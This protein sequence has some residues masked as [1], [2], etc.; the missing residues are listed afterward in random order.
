M[1]IMIQERLRKYRKERG[2]TQEE[3]AQHLGISV[4]AVSKWERGEGYPDITLLPAIASFYNVTVDDLLGV[5]EIEKQKKYEAYVQECTAL[6]NQGKMK[7]RLELWKKAQAEFPNNMQVLSQVMITYYL[8]DRKEHADEIIQ[9]GERILQESTEND[10]RNQA[11]VRIALAYADKG[12]YEQ[13]KK[14]ANMGCGYYASSDELLAQVLPGEEGAKKCQENIMS[15]ISC[16]AENARQMMFKQKLQGEDAVR[17]CKFA[18]GLWKLLFDDGNYGFYHCIACGYN[19]QLA[20]IYA[21]MQN[22][23]ETINILE[24]AAAHAIRMDSMESVQYT[25]LMVNR[26]TFDKSNYVTNSAEKDTEL[27][28]KQMQ[29]ECFDFVREDARFREI[30]EKLKAVANK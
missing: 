8:L 6:N 4:Q 20:L 1:N 25:A 28:L 23:E 10:L 2:N 27:L 22:A 26:C 9:C 13:A 29:V 19:I 14:Y 18:L 24:E 11:I 15:L 12:D 7:E 17:V 3:L 21:E 30:E 16:A 5:G